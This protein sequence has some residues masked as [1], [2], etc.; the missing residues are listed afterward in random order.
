MKLS[1]EEKIFIACFVENAHLIFKPKYKSFIS[2]YSYLDFTNESPRQQ[3]VQIK[4]DDPYFVGLLRTFSD[5][6]MSTKKRNEAIIKV[7]DELEAGGFF[8]NKIFKERFDC[9]A[10]W[11]SSIR[12]N[13]FLN[14]MRND[15]LDHFA[16][17]RGAASAKREKDEKN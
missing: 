9:V 8:D 16:M 6:N 5:R 1:E 11:L 3:T 17:K 14:K 15:R 10:K 13:Y 2:L 4:R 7:Y 12:S